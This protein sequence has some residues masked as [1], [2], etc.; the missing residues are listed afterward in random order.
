M[1]VESLLIITNWTLPE[2]FWRF[3]IIGF[4]LYSLFV[5]G[6][7]IYE[8]YQQNKKLD[9]QKKEISILK[10]EI[11]ELRLN[12][13]YYQTQTFKEKTARAKLRYSLPGE[14]VIAVPYDEQA[15]KLVSGE[16]KSEE[17]KRPNYYYWM[18][19]FFGK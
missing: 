18:V 12:I 11:S 1:A 13:I 5:V 8:N 4:I 16:G 7:I 15:E 17:I 14:T 3:L 9:I 10:N 2:G 19:Y 6:K